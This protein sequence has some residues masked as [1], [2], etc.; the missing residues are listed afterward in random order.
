M[1]NYNKSETESEMFK[2]INFRNTKAL[3]LKVPDFQQNANHI[4]S[5]HAVSA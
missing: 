2:P 3:N 1:K 4:S 5:Q